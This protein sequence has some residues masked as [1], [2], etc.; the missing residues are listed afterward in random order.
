MAEFALAF[1]V[2]HE[3]PDQSKLFEEIH[4]AMKPG[5]LLLVSEPK[6]HVT[7]ETFQKT[8]EAAM[9][10]GFQAETPV[11]IIQ[12]ISMIFKVQSHQHLPGGNHG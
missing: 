8:I 4:R 12:S 10:K 11:D 7:R 3:V 6:G 1:A 2:V 5:S 9:K